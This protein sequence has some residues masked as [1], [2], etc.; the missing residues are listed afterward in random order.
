MFVGFIPRSLVL[1][2][3]KLD[4]KIS[5]LAYSRF[6][7][8]VTAAMLAYKTMAKKVN[9]EFDFIIIQNVS[10]ILPLFCTQHG[11]LITLGKTKNRPLN[12]LAL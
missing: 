10:D 8:D 3:L 2:S 12:T 4:F 7:H 9:W 6:S 5:K 11:C 1:G